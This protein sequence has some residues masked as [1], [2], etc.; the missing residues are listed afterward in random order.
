MSDIDAALKILGLK[1]SAIKIMNVF[2]NR[3]EAEKTWETSVQNIGT[4]GHDINE[5]LQ[6]ANTEREKLE[7]WKT[8]CYERTKYSFCE[9]CNKLTK[10]KH[11]HCPECKC[12]LQIKITWPE[13]DVGV[14]RTTCQK[15][16]FY[17]VR[18]IDNSQ[19]VAILRHT[20]K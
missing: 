19:E 9:V 6:I 1:P 11:H 7:A 18:V 10:R 17:E 12:I 13:E 16:N 4:N 15:C 5:G 3:S 8:L 2:G 20:A 14:E